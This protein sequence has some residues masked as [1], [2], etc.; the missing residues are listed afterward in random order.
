MLRLLESELSGL[1]SNDGVAAWLELAAEAN[2]MGFFSWNIVEDKLSW[3]QG[4]EERMGLARGGIANFGDWCRYAEPQDA[5]RVLADVAMLRQTRSKRYSFR[6]R[7]HSPTLGLRAME[8][9]AHCLYDEDGTLRG[10]VGVNRD[11][12][13]Q[14]AATDALVRSETQFRTIFETVPDALVIIDHA[15]TVLSFSRHAVEM[16]GHPASEVIGKNI[17]VLMP[18]DMAAMHGEYNARHALSIPRVVGKARQLTARRADGTLFPVEVNVGATTTDEGPVFIGVIRD[19]SERVRAAEN[20][21]TLRREYLHSARLAVTGEMA[22]GLAHELN[23][24]LSA[25]AN[26]LAAAELMAQAPDGC[27]N[28]TIVEHVA[29]ARRSVMLAGDIIRNMRSFSASKP[30]AAKQLSVSEIVRQSLSLAL[31]GPDRQRIH[32]NTRIEPPDLTLVADAVQVQQVLVNLI[33]NAAEAMAA[34]P[35][36]QSML[37]IKAYAVENK[38]EILI[39]DLGPGFS[40]HILDHQYLPFR[41]T[42]GAENMGLG[43]S[44][45]RRIVDAMGGS[46]SLANRNDGGAIVTIALPDKR[47]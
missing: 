7:F 8:G 33:R 35:E 38:I 9:A 12:T 1:G 10:M 26:F 2:E 25:A 17:T 32:V 44:I 6:Y 20:L 13:A 22:A 14:L 11:Y 47:R 41:S 28:R 40:Q 45:C 4:A 18:D 21:D 5:E 36:R 16:F 31:A 24:P 23:Q 42:K 34:H 29:S 46:I 15:G 37:S 3:N 27:D 39:A 30:L 19:V 43:L